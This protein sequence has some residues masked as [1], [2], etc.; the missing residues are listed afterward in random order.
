VGKKAKVKKKK[1]TQKLLKENVGEIFITR[2]KK[3]D[4]KTKQNKRKRK[5]PQENIKE[6]EISNKTT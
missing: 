6:N 1:K 2:Q 5:K 3:Q 4:K